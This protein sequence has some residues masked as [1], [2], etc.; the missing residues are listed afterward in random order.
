MTYNVLMGTLNHTHSLTHSPLMHQNSQKFAR[1]QVQAF[2]D[3]G[4][5]DVEMPYFIIFIDSFD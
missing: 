2:R 5:R 4:M 3:E 1:R